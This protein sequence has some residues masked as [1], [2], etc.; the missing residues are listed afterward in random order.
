MAYYRPI[1]NLSFISKLTERIVKN[2]L[3]AHLSSNSLL[4]PFQSAYTKYYSTETTLL[5]LHDHLSNAVSHQQVSCLCLLDLSAAFDT[6]DYSILLTRLSTWFGI[7]SISLKWFSS[8][9]SSRTSVVDIQPNLSP[10]STSTCGVPQGSLLGPILF[11]LYTTPLSTIISSSTI[12]HLLYA[13]DTQLFISFIPK[14]YSAAISNL[15]ST[16]S[17]ISSWMSSNYL[18]LNPTKTDFLNRTS[19]A[20]L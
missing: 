1:S 3:L 20:N 16:V 18:T 19:T 14:Q 8:Y 5:S 4:N 12:S 2:R 7:S 9:L 13:D 10:S 15:Q 17:L 6:L 11:N